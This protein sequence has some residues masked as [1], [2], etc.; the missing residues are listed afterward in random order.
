MTTFLFWNLKRR[1]LESMVANLAH[2]H[3]VDLILLAECKVDLPMLLRR[4]NTNGSP[5]YHYVMPGICQKI[6]IV[7]TFP[8]RLL[9]IV[10]ENDRLAVRRLIL[11]GKL[12]VLLAYTHFVS[13]AAKWDETSQALECCN[14]ADGIEQAET[15]VRHRRTIL[16]GDLNM[17]PFE[18]GVVSARA[19]HGVMCRRIA[20]EGS[21]KVQGREYTYFYNPMWGLL[22]DAS[23]GPPGTHYHRPPVHKTYFWN[24][25]DQ[26]LIRPDL[27]DRFDNEDLQILESDGNTSLLTANGLPDVRV[28][29]DHLPLLF[30]LNLEI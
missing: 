28:A 23:P 6:E 8:Q 30:K 13:K 14:L 3:E 12:D 7:A 25:F 11:P 2:L 22:G 24:M 16:V 10:F 20:Q 27:V 1:R 17:N 21:R 9:P 26:V 29:S 18:D 5:G 19:L 15:Q 4:L